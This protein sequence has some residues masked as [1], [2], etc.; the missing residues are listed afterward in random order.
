M[1][2]AHRD[3]ANLI[4]VKHP[5]LTHMLSHMRNR[6]TSTEDFARML[7][8][9]APFL[10]YEALQDLKLETRIIA[11]PV[12][13]M[14]AQFLTDASM[15]ITLV[16]IL[17]AGQGLITR[18]RSNLLPSAK[19][20]YIAAKRDE[21]TLMPKLSYE[22]IPHGLEKSLVLVVD[23]MLATGGSC[24]AAIS[25]LKDKGAANIRLITLLSTAEGLTK[26]EEDHPDV[27]VYTLAL[28]PTLTL[29]GWIS[30]GL[31]DAGDRYHGT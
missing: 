25:L 8:I 22:R 24:S 26:I 17:G 23:P 2:K 29:K 28:D 19:L 14:R 16:S 7:D 13:S 4:E 21:E 5:I 15:D 10:A 18:M 27:T 6:E 1:H 30:P 20:G 3:H 11:T 31:G 9:I 12:N